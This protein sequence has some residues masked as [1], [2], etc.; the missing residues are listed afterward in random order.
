M[1]N[2]DLRVENYKKNNDGEISI[3]SFEL[4]NAPKKKKTNNRSFQFLLDEISAND[5]ESGTYTV[6]SNKNA[7]I[8]EAISLFF[9]M[10][11]GLI[12]LGVITYLSSNVY[13]GIIFAVLSS[14][15][16]P[17][18]LCF[19][20]YTLDGRG[21]LKLSKLVKLFFYGILSCF[22][23]EI[24]WEVLVEDAYREFFLFVF[25]KSFFEILIISLL[26]VIEYSQNKNVSV[27][28]ALLI[29]CAVASGN[30]FAHAIINNIETLF[31]GVEV[32]YHGEF[33]SV[34]AIVNGGIWQLG[35]VLNLFKNSFINCVY[36]PLIYSLISIINGFAI[37]TTFFKKSISKKSSYQTLWLFL[38]SIG[39]CALSVM[40]SPFRVFDIIYQVIV[41]TFSIYTVLS[42]LDYSIMKQKN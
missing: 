6:A 33:V 21:N 2:E 3:S 5:S 25:G 37:K 40:K 7:K 27:L 16:I 34:G 17:I 9:K 36:I 24:L 4:Q 8:T 10:L 32:I 13:F 18:S 23:I 29:S 38:L 19:F 20:F 14:T 11:L 39:L 41:L 12:M 22:L 1:N 15:L 35:S 28:T 30:V 31:I 42:L 26:V